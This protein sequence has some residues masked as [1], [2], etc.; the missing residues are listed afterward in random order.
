V[1]LDQEKLRPSTRPSTSQVASGRPGCWSSTREPTAIL[2]SGPS[3]VTR[4]MEVV[5]VGMRSTS[6]RTCQTTSAGASTWVLVR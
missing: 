4:V 2:V 5:Q 3:S 6:D 1:V